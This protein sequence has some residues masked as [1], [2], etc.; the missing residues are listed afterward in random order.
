MMLVLKDMS[1]Y[2]K[3]VVIVPS[4]SNQ[5]YTVKMGN[6]ENVIYSVLYM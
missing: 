6:R 2:M 3:R 5:F 1:F 4:A